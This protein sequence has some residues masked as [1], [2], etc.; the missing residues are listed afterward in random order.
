MVLHLNGRDYELAT[1]LRVVYALR[2]ITHA[3]SLQEAINSIQ[4]LDLEGKLELLYAAYKAGGG[5]QDESTTKQMFIDA[6]VDNFG[7]FAIA[8]AI[9]ELTEGLLYSG[10]TPE[11]IAAKK[12]E[13]KAV[14]TAAAA[15]AGETSFAEDIN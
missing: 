10:L 14:A 12:M 6:I 2:D 11:E 13:V 1:S 15:A 8:N 5:K 9:N 3:Q 4:T 7:V